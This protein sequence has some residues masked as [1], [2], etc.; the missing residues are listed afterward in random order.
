MKAHSIRYAAKS[1]YQLCLMRGIYQ[2]TQL[3][4]P[5]AVIMPERIVTV[6]D[7]ETVHSV[8]IAKAWSSL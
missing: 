2:S 7:G 1:A 8:K 4:K 5:C 3:G 6:T